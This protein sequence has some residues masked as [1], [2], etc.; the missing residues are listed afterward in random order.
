MQASLNLEFFAGKEIF[1]GKGSLLTNICAE[2]AQAKH[3][4]IVQNILEDKA[5][6]HRGGL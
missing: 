5:L 4:L 1:S 3:K 6:N 2:V